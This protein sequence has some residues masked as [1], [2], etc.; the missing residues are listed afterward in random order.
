[1]K[2]RNA[3]ILNR[4]K[5]DLKPTNLGNYI[6]RIWRFQKGDLMLE[7]KKSNDVTA[8]KFLN[9]L[10]WKVIM[11]WSRLKGV[12]VCVHWSDALN[13]FASVTLRR[14][15]LSTNGSLKQCRRCGVGDCTS[16]DCGA[17]PNCLQFKSATTYCQ[18]AQVLLSQTISEKNMDAAIISK[19]YCT[20]CGG[21][22][23]KGKMD[24]AALRACVDQV[25]HNEASGG[26]LY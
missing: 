14:P 13:T 25:F 1:M 21:T 26:T 7:L 19:P 24:Q 20:Q 17:H 11:I 4:V 3:G 2:G 18:A 12:S 6:S 23:V 5:M 22:L 15:V 9:Q 16:K 10:N 8:E